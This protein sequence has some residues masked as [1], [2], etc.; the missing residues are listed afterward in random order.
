MT[1]R[2][3]ALG[4]LFAFGCIPVGDAPSRGAVD[5]TITGSD[6]VEAGVPLTA[7]GWSMTFERN[8][9]IVSDFE[10]GTTFPPPG[11][12]S[13]EGCSYRGDSP[14]ISIYSLHTPA[15]ISYRG[16]DPGPC[17]SFSFNLG[18]FDEQGTGLNGV[19]LYAQPGVTTDD[20]NALGAVDAA[21]LVEGTA[22]R[23]GQVIRFSIPIA[24]PPDGAFNRGFNRCYG[25]RDGARI[26]GVDIPSFYRDAVTLAFHSERLFRSHLPSVDHTSDDDSLEFTAFA[27][28]DDRGNR[29]GLVTLDEVQVV[30][31][32]TIKD[33]GGRYDNRGDERISTLSEFVLAQFKDIWSFRDDGH[34]DAYE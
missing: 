11:G 29:D 20:T 24:V 26:N 22:R 31:L 13:Y 27:S 4:S 23:G 8:L 17:E 10:F 28:A 6:A 2:I 25:S 5:I 3:I 14:P 19:P 32:V 9:V 15:T 7:D 12:Y 33:A 16:F 1:R 18:N 30:P 21:A 34:C